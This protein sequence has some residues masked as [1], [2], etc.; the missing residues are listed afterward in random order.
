MTSSLSFQYPVWFLILCLAAG[1]AYAALLYY[2]DTTFD[3]KSSGSK[4]W[5]YGMTAF[6]FLAVTILAILL[7]SPFI[8][9]RNTQKFKPVVAI[10]NDNSESVKSGLK[11]DTATYQKKL[12]AL[13]S[14]LSDKYEVAQFNAGDGL[15]RDIDF[16][17]GDKATDLS[18]AVDEINGLYYNQNLGAVVIAS[19]GIYNKGV[20]P[21]YT[22]AKSTY[23]IYTIAL[24]DTTIQ[25]D[26]KLSN[27]YYNKI[28]YLND[29]FSLRVD[30]EETNL[31]GRNVK[32][33]VY[34]VAS[35]S[36]TKL[37]QNKDISYGS[38][39]YFQ[40]FDFVLP[41]N[42]VGI[43]HYRVVLSNTEGEITYRNNVRDIFVEVLDGRQ[44]ILLVAQSPHPDIAA[45]KSAIESN[46]NYQLDVEFAETFSKKLND[47][48]LVILHQLPSANNRAASIL[49]D[50]AELK[51]SLL[52][53]VGSQTLLPEFARVQQGLVIK[54]NA[55]KFNEVTANVSKD[56]ALFTLSDKTLQTIPK[57]PPFS[58]FFGEYTASPSSKVLLTQKINSVATDFPLWLLNET[59]EEK[60]GVVC[61][62]GLWRWRLYDYL[63]NKKHDATNELINKTVQYL[64]VKNDKRP[65]RV[66]L[67]KNIFQDNEAVT[68][69]AQLYNANYELINSPD[70]EMK[71]T[72][73]DKTYD[74]KFSKTENAYNLNA[75][76]LP[77]GNYSYTATTRLGN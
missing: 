40:S 25:K 21:V 1:A 71:I 49:K 35:G 22:A 66:N 37:V 34:E 70:V 10:I 51:K 36:D 30:V 27:A 76:F 13:I 24:G 23:S 63:I 68:F 58:C 69:D 16:L 15:K 2:R 43:A 32:L 11:G 64:A 12:N 62:E 50:A 65:F 45:F 74:Y 54:G 56:F 8:R 52:F 31:S 4:W 29:Q 6:R 20:N 75:G 77:V 38:D 48:N 46:K 26:Q 33:S 3:E 61:G 44:K 18:G 14:K 53:V 67:A 47:Y 7:L 17:Y 57:L 5:K 73:E 60:L 19:D 72:G 28:A 9:T 39:N 55:D 41:A 59:G 42:K